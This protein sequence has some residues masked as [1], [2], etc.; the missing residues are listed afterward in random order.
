MHTLPGVLMLFLT[1]G[2]ELRRPIDADW[3]PEIT[4]VCRNLPVHPCR[5]APVIFPT[6]NRHF[7]RKSSAHDFPI[8]PQIGF[9]FKSG[10]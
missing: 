4:G 8:I 6:E 10:I 5:R 9:F 2:H 3:S 7:E 1:D